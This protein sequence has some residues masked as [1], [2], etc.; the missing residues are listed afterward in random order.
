MLHRH[1]FE[2]PHQLSGIL[3]YQ[4]LRTGRSGAI[5]SSHSPTASLQKRTTS[6]ISFTIGLR[7]ASFC[8]GRHEAVLNT[9]NPDL[10]ECH[11]RYAYHLLDYRDY[12]RALVQGG[13]IAKRIRT[14]TSEAMW[15]EPSENGKQGILKKAILSVHTLI[16]TRIHVIHGRW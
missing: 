4:F 6:F 16:V 14:N 9:Y 1:A 11:L 8:K 12:E 3:S 13:E 2:S 10:P 15:L 7:A 5:Q